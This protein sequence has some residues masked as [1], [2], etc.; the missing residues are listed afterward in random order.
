MQD[1]AKI[2]VVQGYHAGEKEFGQDVVDY[3]TRMHFDSVDILLDKQLKGYGRKPEDESK[4][5][6]EIEALIEEHK[7]ELVVDLHCKESN[8]DMSEHTFYEPVDR[9]MA[10][11]A[12]EL[13]PDLDPVDNLMLHVSTPLSAIVFEDNVHKGLAQ[14]MHERGT[15]TYRLDAEGFVL[16]REGMSFIVTETL[17]DVRDGKPVK[18]ENY[19]LGL[20]MTSDFLHLMVEYVNSNQGNGNQ[21]PSQ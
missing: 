18:N 11:M 15:Q 7:P 9:E 5:N 17:F 12:L 1:M 3:Y 2:L 8:Y 4:A 14:Y 21:T 6:A 13:F 16:K 10:E 19:H 20:Q